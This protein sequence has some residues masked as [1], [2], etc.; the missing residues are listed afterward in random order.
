MDVFLNPDKYK[1]DE[2]QMEEDLRREIEEMSIDG[3]DPMNMSCI[4][5][6]SN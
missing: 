3:N 5:N 6:T 2:K 1:I 4:S